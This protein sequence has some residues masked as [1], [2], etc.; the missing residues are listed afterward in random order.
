MSDRTFADVDALEAVTAELLPTVPA[1]RDA[2][3][4]YRRALHALRAAPSDLEV[5]LDDHA[6]DLDD[7]ADLLTL[8]DQLPAAFAFALRL[9]DGGLDARDGGACRSYP[10]QAVQAVAAVRVAHPTLSP[11]AVRRRALGSPGDRSRETTG[12]SVSRPHWL[13][14]HLTRIDATLLGT[15]V[16]LEPPAAGLSATPRALRVVR[17]AGRVT[18]PLSLAVPAYSQHVTDRD[19]HNLTDGDRRVG[20]AAATVAEGLT[21]L[22]MGA[23]AGAAVG[24]PAGALVGI[25]VALVVSEAGGAARRTQPARRVENR[26]AR[27]VDRRRGTGHRDTYEQVHGIRSGR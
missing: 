6:P 22:A 10:D 18:G 16:A 21:P 13:V 23:L 17:G 14:E 26:L 24:G 19:D 25:A 27:G 20:L 3:D 4:T 15:R 11:G 7:L 8:L 1:L 12:P 2:T 9:L 5:T